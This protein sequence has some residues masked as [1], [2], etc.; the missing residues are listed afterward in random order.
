MDKVRPLGDITKDAFPLFGFNNWSSNTSKLSI[1]TEI[2][3]IDPTILLICW[4]RNE[5]A[6]IVKNITFSSEITDVLNTS[7]LVEAFS[8]TLELMNDE[9]FLLNV[10]KEGN[11]K[12]NSMANN[13]L[14]KIYD[15]VGLLKFSN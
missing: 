13:N 9:K 4:C 12:A 2:L 1:P 8:G 14:N 6:V 11:L 5:F 10:L 3:Y 7:L 15:K